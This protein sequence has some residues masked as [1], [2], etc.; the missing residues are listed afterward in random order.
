MGHKFQRAY[1]ASWRPYV[2]V[3]FSKC[4]A[5]VSVTGGNGEYSLA[6]AEYDIYRAS[7]NA[8]IAHIATDASGHAGYQLSPNEY[9][10]A[11]ETKAPRASKSTRIESSSP[12]GTALAASG[13]WTTLAP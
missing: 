9:Y 4:S 10:Y 5:D 3:S 2:D 7:D 11:V 1:V 8:L 6:G 12:L 13:W